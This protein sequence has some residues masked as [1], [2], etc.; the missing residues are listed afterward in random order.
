MADYPAYTAAD[1]A[2][3]TGRDEESIGSYIDEAL[4]QATLLFKIG[5]CLSQFPD[6]T[7][8]A[9]IARYGILFMADAIEAVQPYQKVLRNPFSAETIGSYSYAKLSTAVSAGLPT[10]VDWFDIAT[11]RLSVC[12]QELGIPASGGYNVFEEYKEAHGGY[13]VYLGPTDQNPD[14]WGRDTIDPTGL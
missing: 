13:G 6:A 11:R 10:G 14:T 3:A 5:T 9:Q 1:V 8:D 4:V 7:M 12:D 2:A